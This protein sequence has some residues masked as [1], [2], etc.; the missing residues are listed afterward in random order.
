MKKILFFILILI[1]LNSYSF[2]KS[3]LITKNNEIYKF[4]NYSRKWENISNNLPTTVN[5]IKIYTTKLHTYLITEKSGIFLLTKNE[6]WK[7][8][9][10]NDFKIRSIYNKNKKYRKISAFTHDK[11]NPR[12]LA[13]AT[14]H[15]IYKSYN[16]GK[17]WKKINPKGLS[18]RNYITA[19][20]IDGKNIAIGTS[21]NGV[22]LKKGNRFR[23]SN[24]GLP[25]EPYSE[26]LFFTE[27]I[28][29]LYYDNNKNLY[30]GTAFGKGLFKR[31]LKSKFWKKIKIIN[32]KNYYKINS[33]NVYKKN[34]IVT[35]DN[36]FYSNNKKVINFSK[37]IYRF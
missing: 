27:Q 24:K 6:N 30:A 21:F 32:F 10:S 4:K 3:F 1:P 17:S 2:E 28:D 18:K 16:S 7:N 31:N 23:S 13:L 9:S 5:P 22:Y 19:L 33:I 36:N 15:T 37:F 29:Q 20:A 26:R 8:I 34:I 25:Q 11:K 35:A 14:K 12:N